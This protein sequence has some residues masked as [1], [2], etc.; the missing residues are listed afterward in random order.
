MSGNYLAVQVLGFTVGSVLFVLLSVLAWRAEQHARQAH[1][2]TRAAVLC[3]L[4]NTG[5][6]IQ[7]AVLLFGPGYGSRAWRLSIIIAW[8]SIAMLPTA[9]LL[10]LNSAVQHRGGKA[11]ARQFFRWVSLTIAGALTLAVVVT[12]L[13]PRLSIT[14]SIPGA[15][16]LDVISFG[17]VM[18]V[19]A[20]NM[21]FHML[22]E[23]VLFRGAKQFNKAGR[24]YS[25]AMLLWTASLGLLLMITIHAALGA[26]AHSVLETVTQ[27]STIPIAIISLVF[28]GQFR[29][30]DVFVKRSLVIMAAVAIALVYLLIVVGPA[31]KA[32]SGSGPHP[33]AK[34]WLASTIL[35]ALL[36]LLFPAVERSASRAADRW[37]FRRPDYRVLYEKFA[38]D[39]DL[40]QGERELFD[41]AERAVH[42]A[43]DA[44]SVRIEPLGTGS[45][46]FE[47]DASEPA[48]AGSTLPGVSVPVQ[49]RG[50]AAYLIITTPAERGRRLL[51]E[52]LRFLRLLADRAGRRIESLS[53][54][55]EVRERELREVRLRQLLAE[56]NL[57][58]LRAQLNPHFL[59][60]TLNTILDLIGSEPEK[61]ETMTER[62]AD[63]FR[64]VMVRTERDMVT[65]GE[66]IDFL[67]RYLEIERVRF[68]DRL[69]V[70]FDLDSQLID[71]PIPSL[72][73]QPLVENAI[74]HGLARKVG[75]GTI[76]ISGKVDGG[77]VHLAVEDDG[78][79]W[80]GEDPYARTNGSDRPGL[81][82]GLRNVRERLAAVYGDH[83]HMA[84][85][86]AP[87]LGATVRI[88]I[89]K[90]DVDD[91]TNRRRG[92]RKVATAETSGR[93]S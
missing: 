89:A 61:A 51:S 54:E 76:R 93:A 18:R 17:L 38:V 6:L 81:E 24:A 36:L 55:R 87:G 72:L 90:R 62:L 48:Q 60:N 1:H 82:L 42:A 46:A 25:R 15:S 83:A 53:F 33:A 64:H 27:Q 16:W 40:V 85:S 34:V 2:G 9:V 23:L 10:L 71:E 56:A 12:A 3:F 44:A 7:Y 45:I 32:A 66:E 43:V 20:Y 21:V 30:A 80:S 29:F 8:C 11:R 26:D 70:S 78:V 63:V 88:T 19:S 69:V 35:W 73:L 68:G 58:A 22:S 92:I 14:V 65:V 47:D 39:S 13:A 49:V 31:V 4:W 86:S 75:Q 67:H 28:L 77:L 84:V 57:K 50:E 91:S 52:E 5:S 37:L 79:G 59:F 74:K 41:L